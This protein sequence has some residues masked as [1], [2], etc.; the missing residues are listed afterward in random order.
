M[1]RRTALGSV[2]AGS[3]ALTAGCLGDVASLSSEDEKVDSRTRLGTGDD[4]SVANDPDESR[5]EYDSETD[6]VVLE[7][8]DGQRS[9][10]PFEEYGTGRAAWFAKRAIASVLRDEDVFGQ[11]VTAGVGRISLDDLEGDPSPS[12]V[13]R[14]TE[15]TPW[16]GV[17]YE[18]D[19]EG[20]L[21]GE[22]GTAFETLVEVVPRTVESTVRFP[23]GEYTAVF[24]GVCRRY[25]Q[26]QS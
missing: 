24:P 17:Y 15:A 16:A 2:L 20:R 19:R 3:L 11:R 10:E 21:I 7:Y 8:A 18:Y 23:E 5:Y 6:E 9:R 25:W 12:E 14:D 1:N 22:P 26:Q 13:R 4:V